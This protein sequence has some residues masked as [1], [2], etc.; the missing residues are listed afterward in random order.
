M[1]IQTILKMKKET[2]PRGNTMNLGSLLTSDLLI[3]PQLN[4]L[5]ANHQAGKVSSNLLL[6][7]KLLL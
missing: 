1:G 6:K 4:A 2:E 3:N 5:T 7:K